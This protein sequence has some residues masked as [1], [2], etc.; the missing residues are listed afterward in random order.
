MAAVAAGAGHAHD[1]FGDDDD[2]EG[3]DP[4]V[5]AA[6]GRRGGFVR[7]SGGG[8]SGGGADSSSIGDGSSLSA[9]E[10]GGTPDVS[11][12]DPAFRRRLL[13]F[14]APRSQARL[15]FVLLARAL[16]VSLGGIAHGAFF[17]GPIRWLWLGARALARTR[18]AGG[19][20]AARALLALSEVLFF[21][22]NK[23]AFRHMAVYGTDFSTSS[24]ATYRNF[25]AR[26]AAAVVEQDKLEG[27]LALVPVVI[28]ALAATAT[29][30]V[31]ASWGSGDGR[32]M[33]PRIFVSYVFAALLASVALELY[34]AVTMTLYACFG[35]C[36]GVLRDTYPVLFARF[37]RI[38][39][40][41]M[42][43]DMQQQQQQQQQGQQQ[44]GS[45]PDDRAIV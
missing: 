1:G 9:L 10:G 8:L 14:A 2:E 28:G 19:T 41:A 35:E 7:L 6:G 29:S 32:D 43:Q 34:E 11:L 16:T 23:Y 26:G 30:V 45:L 44:Q 3:E 33:H 21:R 15:P 24:H 13:A 22:Y 17:V 37:V 42:V 4:N 18:A 39:E 40:F 31:V 20:R 25:R 38:A 36:P 12:A 5:R 27:F